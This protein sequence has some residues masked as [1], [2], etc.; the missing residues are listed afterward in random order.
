MWG[1]RLFT[2]FVF[3]LKYLRVPHVACGPLVFLST[4]LVSSV[5]GVILR[6]FVSV[7]ID[8]KK[9]ISGPRS[10]FSLFVVQQIHDRSGGFIDRSVSQGLTIFF[11]LAMSSLK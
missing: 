5:A 9:K 6:C 11:F 2:G 1:F 4:L 8:E 7:Q 3:R 10:T